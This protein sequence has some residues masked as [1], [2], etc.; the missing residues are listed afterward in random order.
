MWKRGAL[1]VYHG[2]IGI[3]WMD[4]EKVSWIRRNFF[5]VFDFSYSFIEI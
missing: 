1:E 3:W 2:E 4:L 5:F